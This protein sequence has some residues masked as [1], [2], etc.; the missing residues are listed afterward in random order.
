MQS[1]L[2][3]ETQFGQL[4]VETV[5]QV[6]LKMHSWLVGLNVKSV[7]Y[8]FSRHWSRQSSVLESQF[9]KWKGMPLI[10]ATSYY[11]IQWHGSNIIFSVYVTKL[12]RSLVLSDD[13]ALQTLPILE[14]FF[15]QACGQSQ[16]HEWNKIPEQPHPQR[17]NTVRVI[18][19]WTIQRIVKSVCC[20]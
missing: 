14:T 3:P 13:D 16:Y 5:G 4:L 6:L 10:A 12:P 7:Q 15:I 2:L 9:K 17:I 18:L 11:S 19:H 20:K 8:S 1:S